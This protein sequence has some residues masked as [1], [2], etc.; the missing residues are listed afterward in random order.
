[1]LQTWAM[2]SMPVAC[3]ASILKFLSF[4]FDINTANLAAMIGITWDSMNY[5]QSVNQENTAI[6]STYLWSNHVST[7]SS[8]TTAVRAMSVFQLP[9][10]FDWSAEGCQCATCCSLLGL[11][12][13][14]F[15]HWNKLTS[16]KLYEIGK[17]SRGVHL[18]EGRLFVVKM[19]V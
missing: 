4:S 9:W 11:A 17:K 18:I 12:V 7:W 10:E 5:W 15:E 2:S 16:S 1:M 6:L 14:D 3:N 13:R 8:D 19:F